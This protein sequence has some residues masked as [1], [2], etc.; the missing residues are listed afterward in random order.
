MPEIIDQEHATP[1][2]EFVDLLTVVS[3]LLAK[4]HTDQETLIEP[5]GAR[6]YILKMH[7]A[8]Y[9]VIIDYN[10]LGPIRGNVDLKGQFD[11]VRLRKTSP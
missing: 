10:F 7:L 4:S 11:D 5:P 1:E 9:Q 8:S 6:G 3:P 2:G